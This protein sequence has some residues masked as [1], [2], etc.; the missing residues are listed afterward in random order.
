MFIYCKDHLVSK[1][2]LDLEPA[3]TECVWIEFTSKHDKFL[4]G[5]F[6]FYRPPNSNQIIW[7]SIEQ[8][9]ESAIDTKI[10]NILFTGDFN[11]DQLNCRNTKISNIP[12]EKITSNITDKILEIASQTIR[13]RKITVRNNELPWITTEIKKAMRK[14]DRLR[15]KA[16]ESNSQNNAKSCSCSSPKFQNK[17]P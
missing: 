16:K 11:E 2:R 17:V 14:R 7:D 5:T 15:R 4:L 8:S 12:T 10:K 9:I 6:K 1:R 3:N 13:N